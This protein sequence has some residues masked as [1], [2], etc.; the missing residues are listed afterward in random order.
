MKLVKGKKVLIIMAIILIVYILNLTIPRRRTDLESQWFKNIN[1]SPLVIAHQGGNQERP[2]ATNLAFEHAVN[3]GVDILEFDVALTKDN[4]LVTIHDL[5]L[6]RNTNSTGKVRDKNYSE[7]RQLNA[8]YGLEDRNGNTIRDTSRNPYINAGAYIP[9]LE[10]V[11]SKYGDKKMLIE[12]KDSGKDGKKSV[13]VFWKLVNKY[14]MEEKV[15]VACF[16]KKILKELRHISSGRIAT[17][18]SKKE[19]YSFF[20]FHKL[21]LPVLNNFASFQM[22]H[23]PLSYNVFGIK[24]NLTNDRL[25]K[26]AHKRNMPVYYW[27]INKEIQMDSL[28]EKGVDGIITDRPELLIKILNKNKL[29]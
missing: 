4:Q 27:T 9:N 25:L 10:E 24:V 19:M 18:A 26:D 2:S 21:R 13:E 12:L 20:I 16:D 8:A 7:I 5:T 28:I 29:R 22:L 23:L 15:V 3:I 1:G 17:S 14:N 6:D 11:F